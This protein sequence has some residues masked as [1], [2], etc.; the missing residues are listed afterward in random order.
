MSESSIDA[1]ISSH[2]DDLAAPDPT[3]RERPEQVDEASSAEQAAWVHALQA[4]ASERRAPRLAPPGLARRAASVV[5]RLRAAEEQSGQR[6]T[7]DRPRIIPFGH[8]RD[9]IAVAAMITLAIGVGVPGLLSVQ[10]RHRRVM[11]STNLMN[12]GRG[13]QSYAQ[14]HADSLPFVGFDSRASWL[15]TDEPGRRTVPNRSHLAPLVSAQ[16][17]DAPCFLCPS[18]ACQSDETARVAARNGFGDANGVSYAYQNQA[19]VRPTMRDHAALVIMS[20]DNPLFDRGMPLIEYLRQGRDAANRNSWA[21]GGRGQNVLTLSG[22]VQ[23][24]RSPNVGVNGDNI[25]TLQHVDAYTGREGPQSTR[26]AQLL[27]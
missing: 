17:V 6:E 7:N 27:R 14:V 12:V 8:I 3:T 18:G 23:W 15:P 22:G 19:A 1:L 4:L 20:D 24:A 5:G 21:H 25:W 2:L 11:C 10:E 13:I 9:V 26:D 16:L